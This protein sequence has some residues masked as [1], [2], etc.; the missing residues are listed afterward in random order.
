M[1]IVVIVW[2]SAFTVISVARESF[3]L[4]EF[5]VGRHF[6]TL[7]ALACLTVLSHEPR[8]Q[9]ERGD[10]LRLSIAGVIGYTAYDFALAWGTPQVTAGTASV[11]VATTP[12]LVAGSGLLVLHEPLGPRRVGG[13][14]VAFAGVVVL[15]YPESDGF[16]AD[17]VLPVVTVLGAACCWAAFTVLVKPVAQRWGPI[18][19]NLVAAGAGGVLLLPF[20]PVLVEVFSGDAG[21]VTALAYL[22]VISNAVA[23][24]VYSWCLRR[25]TAAGLASFLYLVPV[26]GFVFGYWFLDQ[27]P[28]ALAVAGSLLVLA[29]LL[30][31]ASSSPGST[32][33]PRV[34]AMRR[35]EA[36]LGHTPASR[37]G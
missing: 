26:W 9:R 23:L 20:A 10:L 31:V 8:A 21:S 35:N 4:V 25:W 28:S 27:S 37:G 33:L 29:G 30:L 32:W 6:F 3:T 15:A 34:H 19:L 36:E 5:A 22:G 11:L 18:R 24:A 13:L 14:L 16:S 17:G 1:V 7:A 12:L 2:G